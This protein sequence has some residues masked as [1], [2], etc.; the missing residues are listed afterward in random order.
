VVLELPAQDG[1]EVA[2]VR[3]RARRACSGEGE[4]TLLYAKPTVGFAHPW[5]GVT[6]APSEKR[7]E[8]TRDF[9]PVRTG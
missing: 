5:A 9:V 8:K 1:D 6:P 2:G 3:A 4:I 7:K